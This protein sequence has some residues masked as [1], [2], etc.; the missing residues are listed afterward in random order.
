MGLQ[1]R[2]GKLPEPGLLAP[3]PDPLLRL[4]GG[5]GRLHQGQGIVDSQHTAHTRLG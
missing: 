3:G 2:G 1:D 5:G 4:P